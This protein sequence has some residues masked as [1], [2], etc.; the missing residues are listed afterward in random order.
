MHLNVIDDLTNLIFIGAHWVKDILWL[1][2][3]SIVGSLIVIPYYLLQTEPLWTP[4]MGSCVFISI[5]ATR[6]PGAS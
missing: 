4:M 1:R 6:T 5:H 3:L 2:L